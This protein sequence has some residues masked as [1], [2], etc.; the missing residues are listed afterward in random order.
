MKRRWVLLL[1]AVNLIGLTALVFLYP[2]FMVA[3]GPLIPEH[4]S[5]V[6]DCF[7][8]HAP[9]RGAVAERCITCHKVADI[10]LRT[11][12]GAAV[13]R[14]TPI[15]P[16]HQGLTPQN[17]MACH[18]DHTTPAL[19]SRTRPAFS[20]ALLNPAIRDN[21][22]SCHTAPKT[23]VHSAATAQCTQCHSQNAW[24]PATFDHARFFVLDKDH[25][26]T[27][28]TCHTTSDRKQYTCYG[29]HEHTE[30]NI[31]SKHIREGISNFTNC[32]SCHRSAHGESRKG[33]EREG[34]GKRKKD[35]D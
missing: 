14:A 5:L 19:T 7:A 31:R 27:C 17:C 28:T 23:A 18:T 16:F 22:T 34:G 11:T 10:G 8:C 4:A 24:K 21:C 20:H 33:S 35:D 15:T 2:H 30:A 13:I 9:L 26:A 6:T 29:C 12:A 32:V 25:N 1:I 3:P